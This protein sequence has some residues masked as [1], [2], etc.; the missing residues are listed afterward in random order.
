MLPM[1]SRILSE[2]PGRPTEG[3]GHA[4]QWARP[5]SA[6]GSL[7]VRPDSGMLSQN[8]VIQNKGLGHSYQGSGSLRVR[9]RSRVG[10]L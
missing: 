3:R 9:T 4:R 6:R 2:G 7:L 8:R 10:R 5:P 1:G